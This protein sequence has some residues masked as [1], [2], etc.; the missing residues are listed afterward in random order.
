MT[1]VLWQ[2]IQA[3]LYLSGLTADGQLIADGDP[4][5]KTREAL[6]AYQE[7]TEIEPTGLFD[8]VTAE[9]MVMVNPRGWNRYTGR[10]PTTTMELQ[11]WL[12]LL[13]F[14]ADG[15]LIADGTDGP[16]TYQALLDHF[17]ATEFDEDYLD[18]SE[19]DIDWENLEGASDTSV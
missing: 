2:K 6:K 19:D 9:E 8:Q 12:V 1:K 4:G 17:N 15:Q 14:T 18:V 7:R 10:R 3:W 11:C 5:E 16:M 13:G